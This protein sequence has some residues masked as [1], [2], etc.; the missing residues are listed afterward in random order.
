MTI[1]RS[2]I[3]SELVSKEI[4]NVKKARGF[5]AY[6]FEIEGKEATSLLV[7]AGITSSRSMDGKLT[8]GGILDF[9]GEAPRTE[10]EFYSFLR[11]ECTKNEMRWVAQTNGVRLLTISIYEKLGEEFTEELANADLKKELKT[12]VDNIG[13]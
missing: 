12:I 13:K 3:L 9:L 1:E 8:R 6:E 2:E 7:E 5:L 11:D 4:A 10:K